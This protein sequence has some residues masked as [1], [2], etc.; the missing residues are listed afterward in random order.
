MLEK[1][2]DP[3]W[4]PQASET[5]VHDILTRRNERLLGEIEAALSDYERVV[6]PWGAL[7]MPWIEREIE[8]L[9]FERTDSRHHLFIDWDRV[10]K[11]IE[12]SP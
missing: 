11:A 5:V 4:I 1:L 8:R 2:R 6:V 7:H 3:S 10:L 9:G 12:E